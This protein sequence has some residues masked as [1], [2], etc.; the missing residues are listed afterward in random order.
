MADYRYAAIKEAFNRGVLNPIQES[1]AAELF[2][3]IGEPLATVG[4]SMLAD[5]LSG[6][7]GIAG[8]ILPG[9]AGQGADWVESTKNALTYIPKTKEGM[10]GLEAVADFGP[11]RKMG[12]Y[13][14]NAEENLGNAGND[15]FGPLGGAIGKTAPTALMELMGLD[16][17]RKMRAPSKV[18]KNMPPKMSSQVGAV[19]DLSNTKKD[20]F[21]MDVYH[22]TANDIDAFDLSKGGSTSGSPLGNLAVSVTPDPEVAN[23]FAQLASKVKHGD[24][25][26]HIDSNVLKLV[27]RSKNP[28]RLD[29]T[30]GLD[31]REVVGA[32]ADAWDEGYDSIMLTNYKIA[33]SEAPRKV[34]LVKDPNQLRSPNAKF[35][36]KDK[37]SPNLL[38]SVVG[39]GV[40][41]MSKEEEDGLGI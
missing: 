5:P 36:L 17:A 14:S 31:A 3:R 35:N 19:G 32:V 38:A 8:T 23:Y 27:L 11:M 33:G 24:T 39:G 9:E 13:M 20:F 7:A 22:G 15:A 37:L 2:K 40:Y 21:N 30:D 6:L 1:A 10:E 25:P 41:V 18:V 29:L 4:S 28:T 12:E 34:I 26:Q 16:L